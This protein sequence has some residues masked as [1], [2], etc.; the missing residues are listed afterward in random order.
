MEKLVIFRRVGIGVAVPM[1][2]ALPSSPVKL[3]SFVAAAVSVASSPDGVASSSA[4]R[5]RC[6]SS[7]GG[8]GGSSVLMVPLA[9]KILCVAFQSCRISHHVV[10]VTDVDGT[11]SRVTP[12]VTVN[13]SLDVTL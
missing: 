1:A 12:H 2:A 6:R 7:L 5:R 3:S 9:A 13:T 10:P 4:V 11:H 8:A